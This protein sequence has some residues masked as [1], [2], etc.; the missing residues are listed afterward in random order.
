VITDDINIEIVKSFQEFFSF[1][2]PST[3]LSKRTAK[4]ESYW[5]TDCINREYCHI[6][7]V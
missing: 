4:F 1:E 7:F 3:L 5:T 2:L 6:T